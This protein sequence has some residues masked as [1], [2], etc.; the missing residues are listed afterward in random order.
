[1]GFPFVPRKSLEIPDIVYK[2]KVVLPAAKTA[3]IVGDMQND[4]VRADG[5]LFVP[6]A[7]ET[8]PHIKRLLEAAREAKVRI[9]HTQDTMLEDD[10]EF[11]I[12]GEHCLINTKGWE[13]ID[14]LAPRPDELVCMKNRYDGFYGT[15]LGHVLSYVWRVEHVVVVGTVSNIC[16]LHTVSSAAQRLFH[17]VVPANGISALTEFDQAMT[18]RQISTI[19]DGDA[20]KS[21]DDIQFEL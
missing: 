21:V 2:K 11:K 10:P 19:Y 18:L 9:A 1:M 8:I 7:P 15:W 5:K 3:M 6:A 17:V 20:V 16:V 14:E 12:W 13:I 4:F